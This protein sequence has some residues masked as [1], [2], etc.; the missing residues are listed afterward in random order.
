MPPAGAAGARYYNSQ[1]PLGHCE[2]QVASPVTHRASKSVALAFTKVFTEQVYQPTFSE[3]HLI[4]MARHHH[5]T[6]KHPFPSKGTTSH[7][8]AK[9]T[10][11]SA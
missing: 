7:Q 5:P 9:K 6:Q 4:F 8:T 2:A 11:V 3:L 1:W 10:E